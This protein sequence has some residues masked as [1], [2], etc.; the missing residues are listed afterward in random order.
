MK[1]SCNMEF[2]S[3][4]RTGVSP[5]SHMGLGMKLSW[6]RAGL[7]RT[8]PWAQSLAPLKNRKPRGA[9]FKILGGMI[10]ASLTIS[11]PWHLSLTLLVP[12]YKKGLRL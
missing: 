12:S 3:R 8:G 6:S 5:E 11:V 2:A 7:A 1:S 10:H 4:L 9:Y